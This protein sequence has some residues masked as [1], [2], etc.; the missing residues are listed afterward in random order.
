MIE[1][2]LFFPFFFFFFVIGYP[3]FQHVRD[4]FNMSVD[5]LPHGSVCTALALIYNVQ[6]QTPA[7]LHM[8]LVDMLY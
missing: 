3:G 4:V 1:K 2:L 5:L 7:A 8:K 6:L